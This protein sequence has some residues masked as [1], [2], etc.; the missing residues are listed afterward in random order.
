MVLVKAARPFRRSVGFL[1]SGHARG[2]RVSHTGRGTSGRGG[3]G[4]AAAKS[5]RTAGV[6]VALEHALEGGLEECL[7]PNR[8]RHRREAGHGPPLG[9]VP[10]LA[11]LSPAVCSAGRSSSSSS[12][13]TADVRH[14]AAQPAEEC[15]DALPALRF[16]AIQLHIGCR[17]V[18]RANERR[19]HVV[20]HCARGGS[21]VSEVSAA[22]DGGGSVARQTFFSPG[23]PGGCGHGATYRQVCCVWTCR[24]P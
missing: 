9:G 5:W 13:S 24:P 21:D 8:A 1:M 4:S 6:A 3:K 18:L 7:C 14:N 20:E 11:L 16:T 17:L 22:A 10:S 23:T 12:R 2:D 19:R 15:P